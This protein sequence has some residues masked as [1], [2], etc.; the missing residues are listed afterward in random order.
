[1]RLRKL[2]ALAAGAA[3]AGSGLLAGTV[4]GG[5]GSNAVVDRLPGSLELGAADT[6]RLHARAAR[7]EA[8][9]KRRRRPKVVHGFGSDR[10]IAAGE[11]DAVSLRCPNKFPVPISG[12]LDA[13]IAGIFPG[14]IFRDPRN[15]R[16]MLIGVANVADEAGF[17]RPAAACM[18][19]VKQA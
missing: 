10:E 13:S 18:K 2:A 15:A 3:L 9:G 5:D 4:I 12:G 8:A 11:I 14:A 19:G 7:A 6:D 16:S 17:W 1:M